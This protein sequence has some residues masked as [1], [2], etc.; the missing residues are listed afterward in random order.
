MTDA[1]T[2][3]TEIMTEVR[4]DAKTDANMVVCAAKTISTYLQHAATTT[5]PV[6]LVAIEADATDPITATTRPTLATSPEVPT[7][8][9][10]DMTEAMVTPC[11]NASRE[12][13][14]LQP[15]TT[16]SP[17]G[18]AEA[19]APMKAHHVVASTQM[20]PLEEASME[21]VEAC[22]VAEAAEITVANT[23]KT[24]SQE[25]MAVEVMTQDPCHLDTTMIA[26]AA[27]PSE[28][29]PAHPTTLTTMA[30]TGPKTTV[31]TRVDQCVVAETISLETK[32]TVK[33]DTMVADEAVAEAA[34]VTDLPEK[35]DTVMSKSKK[36]PRSLTQKA[37]EFAAEVISRC[38]AVAVVAPLSAAEAT[39]EEAWAVASC[40]TTTAIQSKASPTTKWSERRQTRKREG[41]PTSN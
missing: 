27:V 4:T 20:V 23:T 22:E 36:S 6:S 17:V 34:M 18:V 35:T 25:I 40:Q 13:S 41:K 8:V 9:V 24:E 16:E 14:R 15:S 3:N 32:K 5:T 2:M 29:V 28:E 10:V 26:Q 38:E 19:A 1:E 12:T 33:V 37:E 11:V 31:N 7:E 21:D 39:S 30:A